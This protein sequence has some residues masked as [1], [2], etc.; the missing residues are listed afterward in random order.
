MPDTLAN[1]P[2]DLSLEWKSAVDESLAFN[3]GKSFIPFSHMFV[4]QQ[5][6]LSAL[7]EFQ[8]VCSI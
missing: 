7:F 2:K 1:N 8:Y 3:T 6:A 5:I 4:M